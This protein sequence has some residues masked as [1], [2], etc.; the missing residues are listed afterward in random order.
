MPKKVQKLGSIMKDIG[1]EDS[2]VSN[3]SNPETDNETDNESE[4]SSNDQDETPSETSWEEE[5]EESEDVARKQAPKKNN[6]ELIKKLLKPTKVNLKNDPNLAKEITGKDSSTNK[7]GKTADTQPANEGR[8]PGRPRKTPLIEPLPKYG[9]LSKPSDVKNKMEMQYCNP[10]SLKKVFML[11]KTMGS[12]K[13]SITF[14]PTKFIIQG[15]DHLRKSD[16]YVECSGA[17]MNRY[18]CASKFTIQW[19]NEVLAN[20]FSQMG[21]SVHIIRF[22]SRKKEGDDT[23]INVSYTDRIMEVDITYDVPVIGTTPPPVQKWANPEKS[24]LSFKLDSK[25]FRTL[26]KNMETSKADKFVI[27]KSGESDF[28]ITH[29]RTNKPTSL[30][31]NYKYKNPKKIGLKTTL[32]SDEVFTVPIDVRYIKKF[33]HALISDE[34]KIYTYTK[35]PTVFVADIDVDDK[36]VPAFKVMVRT[37]TFEY[38]PVKDSIK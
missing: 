29:A 30:G 23:N 16:I 13:I 6:A 4:E 25:Y 5:D 9:V 37:Q 18:Y 12:Q 27:Q 10:Q 7:K 31:C 20:L 14:E 15:E 2:D 32:S 34:I 11:F 28:R 35:E 33:A 17:H 22:I 19:E 38:K 3:A 36:G 1:I 8:G 26:I 24:P 21:N